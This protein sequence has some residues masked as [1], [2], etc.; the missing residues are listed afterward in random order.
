MDKT[1]AGGLAG[2]WGLVA[3]A[4]VLGGAG[5]G[6]YI[7]I[8]SV[9]IVFGGTASVTAG[10]FEGAALKQIGKAVGV[11][12]NEVKV[13]STPELIEKIIYYATGSFS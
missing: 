2:V 8:P 13:E 12:M 3:L 6:A 9:I 11:A 5:F 4:I 10:Q 7:D 1:T